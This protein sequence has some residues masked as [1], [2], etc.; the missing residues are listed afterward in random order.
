MN[1]AIQKVN[2]MAKDDLEAMLR[3][4]NGYKQ[5]YDTQLAIKVDPALH[6]L[7]AFDFDMRYMSSRL[8]FTQD[9]VGQAAFENAR[10]TVQSLNVSLVDMKE[11]EDTPAAP[12][13]L[14]WSPNRLWENR[15]TYEN[16]QGIYIQMLEKLHRSE[17]IL[18]QAAY[19]WSAINARHDNALIEGTWPHSLDNEIRNMQSK[20]APLISCTS[21]YKNVIESAETTLAAHVDAVNEALVNDFYMNYDDVLDTVRY[22]LETITEGI[23]YLEDMLVKYSRNDTTKLNM[24]SSIT[25]AE[26]TRV[27]ETLDSVLSRLGT[28]AL[29]PLQTMAENSKG[30]IR[31]W[32]HGS[33]N[34]L[35]TLAPYFDNDNIERRA[36]NLN[37]WRFPV[38][39]MDSPSL[40]I[41]TYGELETWRTWPRIHNL[42]ELLHRGDD[43]LFF[44]EILTLYGNRLSAEIYD[45]KSRFTSAKKDTLRALD[46]LK[47]DVQ[48]FSEQSRID[49]DFIL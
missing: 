37:I 36:R 14:L 27:E 2:G 5:A 44:T 39:R 29:D 19:D 9:D 1:S 17:S 48:S 16:C 12:E 22:D 21:E 34:A 33:L 28:H 13:Y 46:N 45:L 30:N 10:G 32:L 23:A 25:E 43:T 40:L 38:L 15:R 49:K 26:R 47:T 35:G 11:I 41:Y 31:K 8:T 3:I 6:F 42:L 18:K 20:I 7:N 4:F 24:S